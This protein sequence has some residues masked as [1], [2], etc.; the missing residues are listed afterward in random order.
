MPQADMP[1]L[2]DGQLHLADLPSI[3]VDTAAWFT[4]L[5]LVLNRFLPLDSP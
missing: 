2:R 3:A 5:L 1:V 4:W